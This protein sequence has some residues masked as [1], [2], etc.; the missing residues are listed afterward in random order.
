MKYSGTVRKDILESEAAFNEF[1]ILCHQGLILADNF[2]QEIIRFHLPKGMTGASKFKDSQAI[3][4]IAPN[5]FSKSIGIGTKEIPRTLLLNACT[6][7]TILSLNS[8]QLSEGISSLTVDHLQKLNLKTLKVLDI[9]DNKAIA[10]VK[11]IMQLSID[12]LS[13]LEIMGNAKNLI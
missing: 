13:T 3:L 10:A 9:N 4:T 2:H 11:K 12:T 1:L 8:P 7:L 6:D 5:F